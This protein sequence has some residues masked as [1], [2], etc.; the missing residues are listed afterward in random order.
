MR[1]CE[2]EKRDVIV[3]AFTGLDDDAYTWGEAAA[4]RAAVYPMG[5][6]PETGVYGEQMKDRRLMLYDG[7][8][9]LSVGMGVSLDGGAPAYRI[10]ALEAWSHVRAE[11]ERIPEGRRG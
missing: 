6:S 11:I 2:R 8:I 3:Y 9:A 10:T 1:L 7:P 4:I 5:Q